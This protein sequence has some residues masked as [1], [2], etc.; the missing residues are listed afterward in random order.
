MRGWSRHPLTVVHGNRDKQLCTP[1]AEIHF[2]LIA[3]VLSDEATVAL[4]IL[5]CLLCK[6]G[7]E[8]TASD[9]GEQQMNCDVVMHAVVCDIGL[10][11]SLLGLMLDLIVLLAPLQELLFAS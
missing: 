3:A 7:H 10:T 5:L 2:Q 4:E 9:S 6:S 11:A 1:A 8:S